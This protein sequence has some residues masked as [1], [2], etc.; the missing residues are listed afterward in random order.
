MQNFISVRWLLR[1]ITTKYTYLPLPSYNIIYIP[2]LSLLPLPPS[3]VTDA[4]VDKALGGSS[5]P[6]V[7]VGQFL[8]P[9]QEREP[10]AKK[11]SLRL[12]IRSQQCH[13]LPDFDE[14]TRQ[15]HQNRAS[16][17]HNRAGV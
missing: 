17:V 8:E 16:V 2:L 15:S 11:R 3:I 1:L 7:T 14:E 10:V 12:Q 6:G 5:L 9:L 4:E 13:R